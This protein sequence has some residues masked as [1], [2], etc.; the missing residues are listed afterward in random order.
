MKFSLYEIIR[1]SFK[2]TSLIAT[3]NYQGFN[4]DVQQV[5][6]FQI[7]YFSHN[8]AI[9]KQLIH[10][11][12]K[13]KFIGNVVFIFCLLFVK[14]KNVY[15]QQTQLLYIKT[16]ERE[17]NSCINTYSRPWDIIVNS[18]KKKFIEG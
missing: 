8:I 3:G 5:F 16:N 14:H 15:L 1:V 4:V 13:C 9:N 17:W 18:E 6:F 7:G 11:F 10:R 2:L 12:L